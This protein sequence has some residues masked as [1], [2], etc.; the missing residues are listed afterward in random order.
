[1]RPPCN[2]T[3]RGR[4]IATTTG[5]R[6]IVCHDRNHIPARTDPIRRINGPERNVAAIPTMTAIA[7]RPAMRGVENPE[8]WDK[9]AIIDPPKLSTVKYR[10][11]N[12][13]DALNTADR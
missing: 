13:S 9:K 12:A 6:K 3:P 10:M 11:H 2:P 7:R 1:M 5:S 4:N 8:Y